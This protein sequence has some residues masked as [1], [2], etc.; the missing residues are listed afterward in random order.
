MQTTDTCSYSV[1]MSIYKKEKPA[2]GSVE[3]V[4]VAPDPK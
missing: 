3:K 2:F 1:L 4:G